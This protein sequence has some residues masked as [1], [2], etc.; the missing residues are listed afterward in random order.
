MGSG[1]SLT[2]NCWSEKETPLV[3]PQWRHA[4]RK[5]AVLDIA[6]TA[7]E[8]L[9]GAQSQSFLSTCTSSLNI[10]EYLLLLLYL[11]ELILKESK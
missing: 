2:K 9:I 8:I 3:L 6:R 1:R 4:L 7:F 10:E 5:K 11:L